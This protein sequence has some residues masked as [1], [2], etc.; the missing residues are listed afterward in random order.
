MRK[1]ILSALVLLAAASSA[2]AD[3]GMW[4]VNQI[5]QNMAAMQARGLK[6]SDDEIYSETHASLKDAIVQLDD[7]S[8]TGGLVSAQGMFFT[9]HHCGVDA[10]QSQS[11]AANNLLR[12]GYWAAS[13]RDELPIPGKTALILVGVE[14]VTSKILS[15]VPQSLPNKEYFDRIAQAMEQLEAHEAKES[16][17]HVV[18]RP[19]FNHNAFYLM[20]YERHLD[21]R[22]VGVPP[23][24]IGNFGGDVDNWHWPRHTGDFCIFRIYTAPDG[25]PA[26][27]STD[28]VPYRPRRFLKIDLGGLNEH[29]FA[30]VMGFPGSTHRYATSFEALHS[31]DVVAPWR[32]EV[33]GAMIN[34]VKRAQAASPEMKVDYTDK[35]DYLV[36]FYQKDV[37]QADAMFRYNVVERL[38]AR[39]DSLRIWAAKNPSQRI[40]YSSALP[41]IK[42]FYDTN[43]ANKWE[44]L[45]GAISAISFYPVGVYKNLNACDR[46]LGAILEHG[47]PQSRLKFWKQDP[48]R[49]NA[50]AIENVLPDIFGHY[51]VAPDMNLYMVGF[52]DL[53]QHLGQCGN[54]PLISTIKSEPNIRNTFPFYVA[55]FYERSYFT[56]EQNLR[57][58]LKHPCRDSLLSDPL[59]MLYLNYNAVW[60]SLYRQYSLAEADCRR[61]SQL[62]TRGL[63]E[64][65]PNKLHYPDANSTMRLTY[66]QVMGYEPSNGR[67]FKPFTTLDGVMEKANPQQEVFGIPP[68][69]YE[70]WRGRGYGR[71]A[72]A[73]GAL[74]VCFIT[75]NDITG[76]NSGSPVLNAHG[77]LVGIAFDGNVEAMAS[78]FMFE[79]DKQRTISVDIRYVL[80]VID[81]VGNA[82]RI[83]DELEIV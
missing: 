43:R 75:N 10:V 68:G 70:L 49:M 27:H 20:R 24:S 36:N 77:S 55:Q 42:G 33:W 57:R 73:D 32:R 76:G 17:L 25:K 9:N 44:E 69:L 3:E 15:A 28:N 11:T 67:Y 31:R 80:F 2:W 66:G 12:D 7:G 82:Q 53:L 34:V 19:F 26:K 14:D 29:D 16:G 54:A 45:Q 72:R 58:L 23:A 60:D 30:M 40:R 56:S 13:M 63:L 37:W 21:V 51:H 47:Q 61:A 46:L 8:C 41:V 71:Y 50:K 48:I 81:K 79:P 35:H 78:D 64:M 39:E 38:A 52:G 59:F 74:P 5:K 62:Y 4:L 6:V 18:V 65:E 1:N 83:L 22:L